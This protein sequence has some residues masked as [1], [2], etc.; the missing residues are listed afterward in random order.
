MIECL[1]S[2]L[3]MCETSLRP[4]V[5]GHLQVEEILG[6]RH[7]G[8]TG[9]WH[10]FFSVFFAVLIPPYLLYTVPDPAESLKKRIRRQE[11][12]ENGSGSKK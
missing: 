4:V 12:I 11:A 2:R 10:S 3:D 6:S 7:C 9:S 5:Q 1:V 8:T